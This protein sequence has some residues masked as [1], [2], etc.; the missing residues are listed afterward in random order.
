MTD[1]KLTQVTRHLD[2][3]ARKFQ[4]KECPAAML[5]IDCLLLNPINWSDICGSGLSPICCLGSAGNS[6]YSISLA[7]LVAPFRA[8]FA[9]FGPIFRKLNNSSKFV[10]LRLISSKTYK[11]GE[12][13]LH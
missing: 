7:A 3:V 10:V 12:T 5:D 8:S 11:T 4:L 1:R 6:N 9:N 13:P 2:G